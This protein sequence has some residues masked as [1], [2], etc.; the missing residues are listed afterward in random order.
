MADLKISELDAVATPAD[1]DQFATNQG[2]T[3]KRETRA[4]ILSDAYR[5][6]GTDVPVTDGGTGASTA[7]DARTNL[8]VDAAGTDNSTN[9]TLAGTPDYITIVGQAITRNA[10]DLA[11]DVTGDL[12]VAEGGTGASTAADARTNLGLVIGADVLAQQ[13]IGIANDNLLEV[14]GS[15]N[16]DEYARF[17]ASGLE[18]RTESEFKADFNL[19][20]GTDV[21]AFAGTG[22]VEQ[23]S[24]HIETADD[25]T[26][27][28]DLKAPYAYTIDS[29]A[30]KTA[31]GTCTAKLTID[32][33]DVT[34]ISA[35]AV[36]STEDF[37]DA[38]AANAV[39]VGNTVA[40]VIS[41]NSAALD[42]QFTVK[43]TR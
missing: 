24:G 25:K 9:V 35:L 39:S 6:G 31:S 23:I 29:L 33:T 20:I 36:S 13:T 40:L 5:V 34:G 11:A 37:D 32:G 18:G 2:G 26:Y 3:T 15:P 4:Q 28:L 1:T 42:L 7:A 10:I 12:P 8:G 41:S 17:T 27:V 19:E 43:I 16:D 22:L 21:L 14:D 30:A 38:S